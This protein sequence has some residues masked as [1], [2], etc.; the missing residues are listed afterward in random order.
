MIEDHFI[1]LLRKLYN[2][3]EIGFIGWFYD[4]FNEVTKTENWSLLK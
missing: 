1:K 4:T 2:N 3:Y